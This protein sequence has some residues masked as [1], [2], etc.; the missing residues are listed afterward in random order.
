M[1]VPA[2]PVAPYLAS[3]S[4]S[5]IRLVAA[6]VPVPLLVGRV[7]E[8]KIC[9]PE[10]VCV[11]V[12]GLIS[13]TVPAAFGNAMARLAVGLWE[14]VVVCVPLDSLKVARDWM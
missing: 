6:G 8:A 5:V 4:A 7:V 10:N 9:A 1:D 11:P 13:A 3:P 12:D 14:S 2:N